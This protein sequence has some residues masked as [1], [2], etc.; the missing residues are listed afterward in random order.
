MKNSWKQTFPIS[1]GINKKFL[2]FYRVLLATLVILF[3][4]LLFC[5]NFVLGGKMVLNKNF[6]AEPRSEFYSTTGEKSKFISDLYPPER[7]YPVKSPTECFQS[8][9]N[10][11]VYFKVSIPKIFN[12]VKVKL[13]YQ[14]ENQPIVQLGILRKRHE[15]TDWNFQL[16]LIENKIFDNLDWYKIKE[17]GIILWQKKKRFNSVYQFLNNLPMDQKTA[18]FFYEID[19]RAIK[20]KTKVIKWNKDTPLEQ[21]DYIIANY[22]EPKR[23]GER[24]E[25]RIEFLVGPDFINQGAL[26]FM[27]SAPG[28]EDNRYEISVEKIEVELTT[29]PATWSNFWSSARDYL[30]RKIRKDE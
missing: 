4:S 25:N 30:I 13:V 22:V 17:R 1:N 5:Q 21:V 20:D 9:Y 7:A 10:E 19:P 16:K 8:F 28:L 15:A 2:L 14:N 29:A 6:C 18:T 26:E 11:P 27:I 3:F 23:V 24:I 12:M